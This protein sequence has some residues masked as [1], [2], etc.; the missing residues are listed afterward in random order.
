MRLYAMHLRPIPDEPTGE[1]P[2]PTL[3]GTE[4]A[5]TPEKQTLARQTRCPR[6]TS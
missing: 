3:A 4:L 2:D 5:S 1:P 6:G